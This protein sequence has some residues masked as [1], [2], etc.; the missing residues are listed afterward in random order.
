MNYRFNRSWVFGALVICLFC[1]ALIALRVGAYSLS[2]SE[3]FTASSIDNTI[4]WQIRLPRLLLAILI[5]AGLGLC[6]AVMQGLFRNPLADPSLIGISSGAALGAAL[7]IVLGSSLSSIEWVPDTMK[8][9]LIPLAAFLMGLLVT[10]LI[11]RLS[12]QQ[13]K[14]NVAVLLLAGVAIQAMTGAALGL[15]SYI[16][17]DSQLRDLTFW[18]MGSLDAAQWNMLAMAS[19]LILP[20]MLVLLMQSRGLNALMLGEDNAFYLGHNVERLKKIIIAFTALLIGAAV[21]VSGNIGFIGLVVPHLIRLAFGANHKFLLPAS[22]MLGAII[23]LLADTLSR[24]IITPAEL[25][26]GIITALF[27]GPFFIYLLIKQRSQ[28][29]L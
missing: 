9:S 15:L 19:A 25:P 10:I 29:I 13:G 21:S 3:I 17:S 14:T 2:W 22:M 11:Y 20:S 8:L 7:A 6:G 5:G 1:S 16:A 18:S 12:Q 24:T 26:I 28:V 27:G 23:L 4:L